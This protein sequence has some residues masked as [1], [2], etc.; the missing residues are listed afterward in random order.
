[1]K[2][3]LKRAFSLKPFAKAVAQAVAPR[4]APALADSFAARVT[5]HTAAVVALMDATL[6]VSEAVG[7]KTAAAMREHAESLG[8]LKLLANAGSKAPPA[9]PYWSERKA[10]ARTTPAPAEQSL[11]HR[12]LSRTGK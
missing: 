9:N 12:I 1:M 7:I 11:H 10:S 2:E 6:A 8:Y 3:S 5:A 4:R